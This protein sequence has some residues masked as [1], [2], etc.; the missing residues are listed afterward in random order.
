MQYLSPNDTMPLSFYPLCKG[1]RDSG[2]LTESYLQLK[3]ASCL[4]N[5][6]T[7]NFKCL[8]EINLEK[9]GGGSIFV[10]KI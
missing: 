3:R 7:N 10:S 2:F 6:V 5:G 9:S 1:R 8:R 4:S